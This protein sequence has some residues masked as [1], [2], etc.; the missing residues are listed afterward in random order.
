MVTLLARDVREETGSY[1]I[2]P[3]LC[4]QIARYYDV[5]GW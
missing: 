2:E 3:I 4:F 1:I 5:R